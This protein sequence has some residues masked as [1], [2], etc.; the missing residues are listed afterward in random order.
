[1]GR[2]MDQTDR[3]D[4]E[5]ARCVPDCA[6]LSGSVPVFF[7]CSSRKLSVCGTQ[8]ES[9][10]SACA[11]IGGSAA[12]DRSSPSELPCRCFAGRRYGARSVRKKRDGSPSDGQ[13]HEDHDLYSGAGKRRA[14]HGSSDLRPRGIDAGGKAACEKRGKI[15]PERSP[16][17]HD[18][19][20]PQ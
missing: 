1:M 17:L 5:K 19:G 18:A 15:P 12:G 10:W 6:T 11:G 2:Q 7:G 20:I 4:G 8:R 14:G 16:V 3:K 9:G 13:Y